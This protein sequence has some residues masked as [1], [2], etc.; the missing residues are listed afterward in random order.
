[1]VLTTITIT[2]IF[3]EFIGPILAKYGLKKAGEINIED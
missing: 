2:C 3:F 1:V